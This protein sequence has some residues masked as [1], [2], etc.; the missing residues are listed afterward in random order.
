[1]LGRRHRT[2]GMPIGS[3]VSVAWP[4]SPSACSNPKRVPCGTAHHADLVADV[5][6][7]GARRGLDL[8]DEGEVA[9]LHNRSAYAR[10]IKHRPITPGRWGGACTDCPDRA[11]GRH[12]GPRYKTT[13][14]EIG[15]SGAVFDSDELNSD[16]LRPSNGRLSLRSKHRSPLVAHVSVERSRRGKLQQ[17]NFER[18]AA[19]ATPSRPAQYAATVFTNERKHTIFIR[20]EIVMPSGDCPEQD[21]QRHGRG[22]ESHS[23]APDQMMPIG[24]SGRLS[25]R[26]GRR[27]YWQGRALSVCASRLII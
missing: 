24:R 18:L 3:S 8:A 21:A 11:S 13:V 19:L 20:N 25:S 16:H 4:P 1:L 12:R 6:E 26:H 27:Q 15:R 14:R 10:H 23:L 2:S 7:I 9:R 5:P 17:V 22:H